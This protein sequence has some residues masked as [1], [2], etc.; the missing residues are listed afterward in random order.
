M[1]KMSFEKGVEIRAYSLCLIQS[2]F[3]LS[4][5]STSKST[6]TH[7]SISHAK[8]YVSQFINKKKDEELKLLGKSQLLPK[9]L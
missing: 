6:S 7:E 2:L 4:S 3:Y 9:S 8:A 1:W 5:N